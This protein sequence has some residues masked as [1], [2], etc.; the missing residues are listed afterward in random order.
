[1]NMGLDISSINKSLNNTF[2]FK[3]ANKKTGNEFKDL[4]DPIS[5]AI[6]KNV[7]DPIDKEEDLLF[8]KN[9]CD[10]GVKFEKQN[11]NYD[12]FLEL[13]KAVLCFPPQT[14]SGKVRRAYREM[15]DRFP[16][17][18][19]DDLK[20]TLNCTYNTFVRNK[21]MNISNFSAVI[22]VMDEYTGRVGDP[23][24]T[25]FALISE[26]LM[27]FKDIISNETKEDESVRQI[28]I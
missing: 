19:A 27:N 10:S 1:M 3:S 23:K 5:E 16:K 24:T 26:T 4:L 21:N 7:K 8:W 6:R 13:K 17:N 22:D 20:Y 12:D 28:L 11:P 9:T 14:A 25:D 2:N 18:V 15:M